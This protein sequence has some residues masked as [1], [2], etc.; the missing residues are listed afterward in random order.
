MEMKQSSKR[1]DP[2]ASSRPEK[3][4][5]QLG[6][7]EA[8]RLV[9][10]IVEKGFSNDP[11]AKPFFS[12]IA[13]PKPTVLP[14]P[15]ARHR[16]HGPHWGRVDRKM[17]GGEGNVD[18]EDDE[19]GDEEVD[20][21]MDL[22]RI[23]PFAKPI[24]RKKK[25]SM[26]FSRWRE[27]SQGDKSSMAEKSGGTMFCLSKTKN[28]EKD[29]EAIETRDYTEDKSGEASLVASME[30]DYSKPQH[31]Q[32]FGTDTSNIN[33]KNEVEP[34]M[35]NESIKRRGQTCS[36]SA[37]ASCSRSDLANE[38][39]TTSLESQIDAE[40]RARLQGMSHDEIEQ[41]Q[42][43]IMEKMN[44]ALVN[45]LKKRG[46]EKL[47]QKNC[48]S[49]TGTSRELDNALNEIKTDA[50]SSHFSE[51]G[52]TH[53][54]TKSISKNPRSRLDPAEVRISKPA[55]SSLWN[56]WSERVEAI[57]NLRF[58]LD[59]T[60][61]GNDL[62]QVPETGDITMRDFLRTEG[63]PGAAGYTIK[64]AVALTRSVVP[65]QRTLAF[66][67]LLALLDKALYNIHQGQVGCI[68]RNDNRADN[69]V[70]WEAVWAYALGPEPE[71]VLSL[72]ICLDDN[73]SSVVLACA[74]VIQ[75]ILSCDANENFFDLLEKSARVENI[76]TAPVFRSKPEIDVGF[77]RGGFW[78]YNAKPSN[79][80]PLVEDIIDDETEGNQTIQDDIV[81][82][83]QDFVA[84]LVRMGILIRLRYLLESDLTAAL[85]ECIVSILI[86]IARHSP[87][88]AN[89]IMRCQRLVQTVV[90]R[91]TSKHNTEILPSKIKSVI[92]VKVLAQSDVKICHDFVRKGIF[93]TMTWNLYQHGSSL[94]HWVKSGL[95][96]CKLSSALMVEQLRFWK[97]CIQHGFCVSYFSDIFPAL[98]LWLNPPTFEKVIE[99]EVVCE[100]ASISK[101]AYLVLKA[102]AGRLPNLFSQKHLTAETPK[103]S[104][105]DVESWSWSHVS[106]IV[107]LALKW[108]ALQSDPQLHNFFE[109]KKEGDPLSEY[110]SLTL[111]L[112]VYSAVMHMLAKVL[113]RVNLDDTISLQAGG[114][115][116]PWL[117]EFV[118]KI[119]LEIIKNGFLGFQDANATNFG[120]DPSGSGSF[121][122]KLCRLRQ[123]SGCGTSLAS[124]CCLQ[125]LVQTITSID[126][127]ILLAGKGIEGSCQE[128]AFSRE[129]RILKD[130]IL[131]GSMIELRSVR[132][133]F[134]KLVTSAWH[135]VQSIERFGRGG[136]AP[137]VGIGWGASGGG[138]WS[139]TILL[140]QNDAGFLIDLLETSQVVLVPVLL[141]EEV[142]FT[143]Q[144][145]SALGITL[146]A[147]PKDRTVVEKAL[148][149][150]LHVSFLKY[151][152]LC[153][154]RFMD[155]RNK[156]F[157]WKYEEEDYLVFSKILTSHFKDRWLSVKKKVNPVD[158]MS[159]S[160]NKTFEKSNSS[161]DTIYEDLD[162]PYS[163]QDSTNL[164]VE[165]A[166]QRLPLPMH[167]FLSPLSTLCDGRH[168]GLQKNSKGNL[169]QNPGDLLEV[170]KA[171][172]FFLLGIE[173]MSR[174]LPIDV[175]SPV[176]SVPL[177]WNLHSLSVILLVGM[178]VIEED[179]SRDVYEALQD[180]YGNILDKTRLKSAEMASETN[181]ALLSEARNKNNLE[182]LRFQSE[183]HESYSTFIETL[184]DQFAAISYGDFIYG[185]QVTVYLHRCVE[186]P[187]RLAAWNALTN[188]RVLELLPTLET[189][190]GGTEGYLEPIEDNADILEAYVKSW[191]SGALDRAVSRRSVAYELVLHHLSS[192]LFHF[193]KDD[194]LSLRNKLAR[195]LLRDSS[196]KLHHEVIMLNLIQYDK[197]TTDKDGSPLD[198]NIDKRFEALIEA[199]ERN[200]SLLGEVE[201]LRSLVKNTQHL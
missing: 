112:W 114:T 79:I 5:L 184:V 22:D 9:G 20:V 27:L 165:W 82:A 162:T 18:G 60:V 148:R 85:E 72:R 118:P 100:F 50:K 177:V 6:E 123:Q 35:V 152:D 104:G 38:Q 180:L 87:T 139:E 116:V 54:M 91:F 10:S 36:T 2:K 170:S 164:V 31:L 187:V 107:D 70:D 190:I 58:S 67:M 138:F 160:G 47:K 43:E 135:Y 28:G 99:N 56:A 63:D 14:F 201:K 176:R 55:N 90:H 25:T 45:L 153:I 44:P 84:G 132:D 150:L 189:C 194:M 151:L 42:A 186:A 120:K 141:T 145:N 121:V 125:G 110:S 34:V 29:R 66:H 199:C 134:M 185:R 69:S 191:T 159:S 74:K 77:L 13:L 157:G 156:L 12:P 144:I 53:M 80:L 73:H 1:A 76:C 103:H 92:L 57:R 49:D 109:W 173:A 71:L 161:L 172:I 105:N 179:K 88:C 61:T 158:S 108:I 37:M 171:G 65:G 127:L 115:L 188:A 193:C 78:K 146:I 68:M 133:I 197:V 166:H 155:G 168:A 46:E 175:P 119:G 142:T 89:A 11:Q 183:I 163:C 16:S 124:V 19:E 130:G 200:S 26:D 198:C 102:L 7:N 101:E 126:K 167:W 83:G 64:E 98:C 178:G 129:E 17:G 113:E 196:L 62:V 96:N 149:V 106:P 97:V 117:P 195:S 111:L 24:K 40:N 3:K 48:P 131:K 75:C 4:V 140:V 192:F 51:S 174:F 33:F 30:L 94:D 52:T 39:G 93:Q 137:G 81:V 122:E 147:G 21:S 23:A 86:A 169:M 128:Y 32:D 41:A 143:M 136:P 181:L 182:F 8:S 95:E 15:V 59:G 154:R